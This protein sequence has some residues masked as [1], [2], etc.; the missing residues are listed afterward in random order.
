MTRII[1][2]VNQKGGVGKTTTTINLASWLVELGKRVL[3]IDIDPQGNASSGLGI[4]SKNLNKGLYEVLLDNNVKINEVI[5][6]YKPNFH[7]LPST[8]DLAGAGIEL[9]EEEN[10]EFKLKEKLK[11]IDYLYDFILIDNP[12]SLGLLTINGLTA[13]KEVLIPV[14][15]E[16]Y[17]L[18]GL[19]QLL[20]T[21]NLIK[22]NLHPNL[23]ILGAI[24]TMYDKRNKLSGDV[25]QELYKHFPYKIFRTV[26]PR[27]VKLAE[28]PSHGLPVK[29]YDFNSLGSRAYRRLAQE[30][31]LEN[32]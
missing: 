4:D 19:S 12:P 15:C 22:D 1:S 29:D 25:F 10:R 20:N 21:I 8:P 6:S 28:A 16:Y 31:I 13:S 11:N 14:Q 18:E 3:I 7:I 17:S 5:K 9:V 24:M 32:K 27:S 26:I 2:I 23:D 30:V